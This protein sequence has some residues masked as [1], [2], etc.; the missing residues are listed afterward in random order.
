LTDRT[1][2]R[3][4]EQ[5]PPRE[6]SREEEKFY[7]V[8]RERAGTEEPRRPRDEAYE[9]GAAA[10]AEPRAQR[11]P[12]EDRPDADAD[13]RES[14]PDPDAASREPEGDAGEGREREGAAATP[15]FSPDEAESLRGRWD[16]VQTEFVDEPR[17]AVEKADA[18]VGD[19]MQRLLDG[20]SSERN[21][22]E[23]EWDRGDGVSTEDLRVALKRYRSFFD[24]LLSV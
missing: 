3:S 10:A 21:R 19:V 16:A 1:P 4:E 13:Y 15:L 17:S 5:E 24:R 12:D 20:F 8:D 7:G 6:L 14:R 18:L 11:R 22:L 9:A 23:R 2:R